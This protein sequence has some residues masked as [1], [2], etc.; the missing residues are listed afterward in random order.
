MQVIHPD[1]RTRI[2]DALNR[3]IKKKSPFD[4]EFRTSKRDRAVRWMRIRG[5]VS[6]GKNGVPDRVMGSIHDK[7]ERRM[8][9]DALAEARRELETKV[10]ARTREP[11]SSNELLRR[12]ISNRNTLQ[13]QLM[14][15][16]EKEQR[17]IGQDLHDS[18]SQ[19]L[20]GIVFMG[21]ALCDRLKNRN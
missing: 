7:T 2:V 3:A 17:R 6:P 8:A 15:I 19:Q 9:F 13:R 14:E 11:L 5:R 20:G 21:Q 12:E 10:K 1:D 4:V 16:S 18:L